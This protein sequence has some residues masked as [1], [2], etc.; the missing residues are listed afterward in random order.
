M[1]SYEWRTD[2]RGNQRYVRLEDGDAVVQ[3]ISEDNPPPVVSAPRPTRPRTRSQA[4]PPAK[5]PGTGKG[6]MAIAP[7]DPGVVAPIDSPEAVA[8]GE[9]RTPSKAITS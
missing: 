6:K 3:R 7:P 5:A 4:K 2:K 9:T 8:A 1:S